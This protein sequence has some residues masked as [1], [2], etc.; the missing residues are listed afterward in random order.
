VSWPV[1]VFTREVSA[2]IGGLVLRLTWKRNVE[3][4][5]ARKDP[6]LILKAWADDGVLEFG[7][8]NGMSGRFVGK[9]QLRSWVVRWLDRMER[10]DFT[11]QRLALERPWALGLTNTVFY[12]AHASETAHDGTVAS[13][14]VVIVDELRRGKL[15]HERVYL[16]DES[17][18]L[19][20]WG[21]KHAGGNTAA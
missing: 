15:V 1:V 17:P 8:T 12:E 4:E 10:I 16:F 2:M 5:F 11:V 20:M 14:D 7:G 21:P 13:T 18:D 6:D 3:K 9:E 19:T